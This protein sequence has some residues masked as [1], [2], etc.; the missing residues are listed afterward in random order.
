MVKITGLPQNTSPA[1]NDLTVIV[2]TASGQTKRVLFSDLV[3]SVVSQMSVTGITKRTTVIDEIAGASQS[4]T[5]SFTDV[6]NATGSLTTSG[7]DVLF[8]VEFTYFKATAGT[9]ISAFR[10]SIDGTTYAP[11]STGFKQYTNE[12][13]SH[14]MV[15]R[16][17]LVTGLSAGA[18]TIKIQAQ[19]PTSGTTNFDTND[20]FRLT[21]VEFLH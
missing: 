9:S 14:K 11:S 12:V 8:L 20:F 10:I 19:S 2:E 6:T 18:H 17:I 1:A 3:L 7:G 5:T 4:I 13:S 21:A 16:S 15:S